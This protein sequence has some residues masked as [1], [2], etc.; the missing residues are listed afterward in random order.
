MICAIA[1]VLTAVVVALTIRKAE[2]R[3]AEAK[4]AQA[5]KTQK[6]L[7]DKALMS[8]QRESKVY[9]AEVTARKVIEFSTKDIVSVFGHDIGIPLSTTNARIPVVITY[10]AYV[11]LGQINENSIIDKGD[12][13]VTIT[14]PD[15]VV[16]ITS[17][18]IDHANSQLRRQLLAKPKSQ[19]FINSKVKEAE[20]EASTQLGLAQKD[21]LARTAR[22]S[23]NTIIARIMLDTG[24][25]KVNV[26]YKD[27]GLWMRNKGLEIRD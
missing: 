16:E 9:S 5:V 4:Q 6:I 14:L 27:D 23:A 10:K 18:E 11:D 2:E 22:E 17:C 8:I 1:T 26:T 25:K 19:E 13:T 15:P 24:Y 12:S 3:N 21:K 7:T 20:R